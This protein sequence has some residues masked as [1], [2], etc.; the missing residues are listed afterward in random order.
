MSSLTSRIQN[1]GLDGLYKKNV[2]SG[3]NLVYTALVR[4]KGKKRNAGRNSV[5][6]PNFDHL[7]IKKKN[8][9]ST[10]LSFLIKLIGHIHVLPSFE[11]MKKVCDPHIIFKETVAKLK[12]WSKFGLL[13]YRC[14]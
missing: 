12:R 3:R 1:E 2:F 5:M 7:V 9:Q 14:F 6:L 4:P 10:F 11:N 13:R 8:F